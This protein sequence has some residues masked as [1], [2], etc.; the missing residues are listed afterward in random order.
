MHE[1][2]MSER[3]Y[4]EAEL[5]ERIASDP[6]IF[7]FLQAGSLDGIWYWDL[8]VP[9]QEWLSSRFK[10]VFGY[11]EDEIPHTSTWWQENIFQEDL[12]AVLERA[13]AHFEDPEVPYD[14]VVRYRHKDGSTV[15]IRC[16]GL[17]I[18]DEEGKPVRML[19]C[20][21]D[22]TELKQAEL[23]IKRQYEQ[24]AT[25]N[26]KL[27]EKNEALSRFAL[28]ASHDLKEPLRSVATFAELLGEELGDELGGDAST[29]LGFILEGTRRMQQLVSDLHDYAQLE[30]ETF[31][32]RAVDTDVLFARLEKEL[33]K[34]PDELLLPE[35]NLS[36]M[37]H[38]AMIHQLLLNLVQNAVKY[39][40]ADGPTRVELSCHAREDGDVYIEVKDNGIGIEP[41]HHEAIFEI[42]QR[43]HTRHEYPGT[44]IGLSLCKRISELHGGD[45]G[46]ES[47]LGEG[48][49]FWFTLP[50]A[51]NT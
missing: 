40:P 46:V 15:W 36:V 45:M 3:H 1:V 33:I 48:S 8:E 9:E 34:R 6:V 31:E 50:A 23:K 14:Q 16:R 42:F 24:L 19:G 18:R 27:V 32:T 44:G 41:K 35:E 13:K 28:I 4:L 11:E 30:S 38:P 2:N 37:V 51:S 5:Y 49:T 21:T 7:D 25:L 10:S 39:G 17:A 20:H 12:P 29:Y 43:L 22:V 47:T 26:K